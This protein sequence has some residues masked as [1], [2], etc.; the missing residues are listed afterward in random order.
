MR[1]SGALALLVVWTAAAAALA[2]APSPALEREIRA[3]TLAEAG[4]DPAALLSDRRLRAVARDHSA[5]MYRQRTLAHV[6]DDG[7]DPRDRVAREHRSLFALIAENVAYQRNWPRDGALAGRFVRS[8]MDSPGHRRNILASYDL[9][10]IGCHGDR[11]LMYCTQL[12]ASS[13]QFTLHRIPFRQAPGAAVT[14]RLE[15]PSVSGG[16]VS[17]SARGARPE[18]PGVQIEGMAARLTLPAAPGLFELHLW[19][20]EGASGDGAGRRY[21]IVS[22]PYVCITRARETR[23]DCGM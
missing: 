18:D 8:W 13:A 4:R 3:Q 16:R 15:R 10:E 17:V 14:V 21:R 19:I 5:A 20:P 9:L 1:I 23:P 2:A 7:L 6:L 22:G 12:F 11:S